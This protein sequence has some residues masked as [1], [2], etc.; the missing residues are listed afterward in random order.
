MLTLGS[1]IRA[2]TLARMETLVRL[3][4]VPLGYLV[5]AVL[6]LTGLRAGIAVMYHRVGEP[7]GDYAVELVPNLGT[8]L[9]EAQVRYL[10]RAFLV[11][12]A[13]EL[14]DAAAARR[15]GGRFPVAITFDDDDAG[16]ARVSA[17]ILRR[18]GATATFFLSGASLSAPYR[19][20][21][22]VFQQAVDRGLH[23]K[24]Q[25]IHELAYAVQTGPAAERE[26]LI[27]ELEEAIG[28]PAP[29]AGMRAELVRE[30]AD[31]GFEI[32]FHTRR[33]E[34]LTLLEED[35]LARSMSDG[36]DELEELA[37][38]P[39]ETIAYPHGGAEHREADAAREAG[40]RWGYTTLHM[41]VTPD[42]DPLLLGRVECS[43]SSLGHFAVRLS[44]AL[45]RAG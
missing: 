6:R 16:H 39:L 18:H 8:R 29:D 14:Y 43:F 19:F 21:W 41:A 45:L 44:R 13:R 1:A 36:R 32:G 38:R 33:H 11:V 10:R 42:S 25:E 26:A 12:P 35:A 17:P 22:E 40:F 15:R 28:P 24:R 30:L 34:Y 23:G 37:G 20:W 9:F 4:G 7:P 31:A 2:D 27:A 5:C 3:V